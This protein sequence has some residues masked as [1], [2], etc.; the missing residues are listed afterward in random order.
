VIATPTVLATL[1][2]LQHR[3]EL[4]RSEKKPAS[5]TCVGVATRF[6]DLD[7]ELLEGFVRDVAVWVRRRR[8]DSQATQLR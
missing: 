2:F 1:R 6:G 7:T 4:K 3:A 5:C 8:S